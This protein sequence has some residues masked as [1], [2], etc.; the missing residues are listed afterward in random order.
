MFTAIVMQGIAI[1]Q[2]VDEQR[3]ADSLQQIRFQQLDEVVVN[4]TR[5]DENAP[6]AH[7]NVSTEQIAKNN[8]GVDLP[9]LLDQQTSVVTTTDAGA[10]VG[11]TGIRIRGSDGTRINVT[12][13]GIPLNDP[14]SQGVWWVNMP[15]LASSTSNIQIQRGVGTSTNGAGAFGASINVNTLQSNPKAYGMI[16]SSYGSFNTMK[17]TV[18]FGSGL[19][20]DKFIFEGRLSDIQSDGY[21]DRASSDLKS[22]YV[23][24]A[25]IGERSMLKAIAFAGHE[26]T[27]QAWHGVPVVYM[28]TNR[29]FNPYTYDNEID[30]YQQSHYQLH[31]VYDVNKY[32]KVNT[33]LHYTRG[34]GYYEQYKGA[35]EN[36]I[37]NY[38]AKENLTD[39]G[40]SPV[41]T[42]LG[43]SIYDTDLIRRRWLDNDFYGA[44]FSAEYDKDA[45]NLIMG[46]GVNQ[47]YG[48]HFG[49]IIWA[50]YAS[51]GSIREPYYNN[52]ALKNDANIYVKANY[53]VNDQLAVF[54][55]MQ[56]RNISYTFLG[57]DNEL[58]NVDQTAKLSFVNPKAGANYMIADNQGVYGFFGIGNKEPN[59]N[60]YTNSTPNSRP[61]HEQMTDI[62]V[63]Y[64]LQKEKY[65]LN[66]NLYSMD[67][68][69]QL[70]LTGEL[71]DVGAAIRQNVKS[72]YRRG[73][74]VSGA[75]EITKK[76]EWRM[77]ATFSQ[78]KIA[79]FNEFIDDWDTGTQIDTVHKKTD[80]AFS[81]SVIAGSQLVYTPI[82]S[83]QYGALELALISKYVGEQ[84]IDNTSSA[85]AKLDAYW[86]H[87]A[88]LQYTVKDKFCKEIIFTGSV[89]NLLNTQYTSNAWLYRFQSKGWNPTLASDPVYGDPYANAEGEDTGR[90][91]LIG[92]FPQASLNFFAGLTLKF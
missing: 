62:E 21:I 80:I 42:P 73:V 38:G 8:Q 63:G 30:N 46:G 86:V 39:Y 72:S 44:V 52:D 89:R 15:D 18:Q 27:Y 90:Y 88:R 10:G 25:Y 91:N 41:V 53:D 55:D 12:V 85:Y 14:E 3:K 1:A 47:Y 40:L 24:G 49:E 87:D 76:L 67:Y 74:E 69:N 28:D 50:E 6:V 48:K 79:E 43:D 75:V 31:Y 36:T 66:V 26:K 92:L 7:E 45:L 77:N 59:R 70:I 9:I 32:V 78:N 51:N 68:K 23:S 33:A 84:F 17:N 71:N 35:N 13:N 4:S 57:F 60:D 5:V 11:Y 61:K 20:N 19:I 56:V 16:S 58:N 37:I 34:F 2:T 64:R 65:T 81:P 29:T 83:A 22:Y 82:N 54:G